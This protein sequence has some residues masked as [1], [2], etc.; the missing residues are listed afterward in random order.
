MK[1]I[2]PLILTLALINFTSAIMSIGDVLDKIGLENIILI[3]AFLIPFTIISLL[4]GKRIKSKI[5]T[6]IFAGT[7]S[8]FIIYLMNNLNIS[9]FLLNLGISTNI[10]YKIIPI[11]IGIFLLIVIIK[12]SFSALITLLGAILIF[13]GAIGII[14][15]KTF[16]LIA[17]II[18][19]ILGLLFMWKKKAKENQL[20]PNSLREYSNPKNFRSATKWGAKKGWGATKWGAKKG[21]GATKI[22]AKTGIW[23]IKKGAQATKWGAK[24]AKKAYN[25][26]GN[27]GFFARMKQKKFQK[28][29]TGNQQEI[30]SKKMT[31]AQKKEMKKNKS[32][33][34]TGNTNNQPKKKSW[35]GGKKT[36]K[37][38]NRQMIIPHKEE[39]ANKKTERIKQEKKLEKRRAK[40]RSIEK[41][42][43]EITQ[44][45]IKEDK[46]FKRKWEEEQEERKLEE[47][48]NKKI[49]IA[50]EKAQTRIALRKRLKKKRTPPKKE[51]EK[52]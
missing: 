43:E 27:L 7:P 41:S 10:L 16:S 20:G 50:E 15:E 8:I 40:G 12:Y 2:L 42:L 34:L 1:K 39:D 52:A 47:E 37:L 5:I 4:I 38:K 24:K 28:K 25:N 17:G 32:M 51:S 22:G 29:L 48:R 19:I 35:F 18:F 6:I 33:M 3:L 49:K 30:K 26:K 11:L 9:D 45:K 23:G 44:R 21:W 36:P 14:H 31:R 46:E 13:A